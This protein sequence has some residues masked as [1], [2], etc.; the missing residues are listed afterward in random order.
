MLVARCTPWGDF[1]RAL[2]KTASKPWAA[3]A[4]EGDGNRQTV[5][6]CTLPDTDISRQLHYEILSKR[7]RELSF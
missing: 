1:Q 4:H 3:F 5:P 6:R 2:C 7:L